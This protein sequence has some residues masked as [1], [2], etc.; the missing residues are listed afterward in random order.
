MAD[1][2]TT[3]TANSGTTGQTSR[4]ATINRS[5]GG[6]ATTGTAS[7][8]TTAIK[9]GSQAA[10]GAQKG[11]K[12]EPTYRVDGREVTRDEYLSTAEKAGYNVTLLRERNFYP[13]IST[14]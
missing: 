6:D 11:E 8:G 10:S 13:E 5:A 1:D 3:N 2:A 7:G 14:Q 12:R 9:S 4:P